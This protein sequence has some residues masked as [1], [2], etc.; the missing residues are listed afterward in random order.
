MIVIIM[1]RLTHDIWAT[2]R[3]RKTSHMS[4][5]NSLPSGF[6]ACLKIKAKEVVVYVAGAKT[7]DFGVSKDSEVW[8][9]T[10]CLTSLSL[11]LHLWNGDSSTYWIVGC[12]ED[13]M[14]LCNWLISIKIIW[15]LLR[16]VP[17]A[18]ENEAKY[19][20]FSQAKEGD[21][22]VLRLEIMYLEEPW[23]I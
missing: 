5:N 23:I 1:K 17:Q 9:W 16:D 18:W 15:E 12:Y 22:N 14:R 11:F 20:C 7:T 8:P 2:R 4:V 21:W 19:N 13:L 3:S 10:C 6:G